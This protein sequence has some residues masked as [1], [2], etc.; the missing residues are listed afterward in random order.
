MIN[1]NCK[2]SIVI[3]AHA[4]LMTVGFKKFV[5]K[6]MWSEKQQIV[7]AD[8]KSANYKLKIE[9]YFQHPIAQK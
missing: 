6:H 4:T 1:E 5:K 3:G 2:L 8:Y 7:D 9:R